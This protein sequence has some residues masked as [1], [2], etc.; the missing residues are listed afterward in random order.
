MQSVPFTLFCEQYPR[1][2][3]VFFST[4]ESGTSE[5]R[6]RR[7]NRPVLQ[8][9]VWWCDARGGRGWWRRGYC[10]R[11]DTAKPFRRNPDRESARGMVSASAAAVYGTTRCDLICQWYLGN[12]QERTIPSSTCDHTMRA[13]KPR[14]SSRC[15]LPLAPFLPS[16]PTSTV[17]YVLTSNMSR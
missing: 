1:R 14:A 4:E 7:F 12:D 11:S 5:P 6:G 9:F 15:Q 16:A 2:S 13:F 8:P 10:A 17:V 3:L